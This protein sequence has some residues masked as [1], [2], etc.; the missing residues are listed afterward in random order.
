VINCRRMSGTPE[1]R[2]TLQCRTVH[3][4]HDLAVTF[5]CVWLV[6]RSILVNIT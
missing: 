1:L 3:H 5:R 2:R 6:Y 4:F